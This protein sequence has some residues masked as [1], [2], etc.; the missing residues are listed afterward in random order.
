MMTYAWKKSQGISEYVLL[1]AAVV[2]GI[3]AM[4]FYVG[5]S[6]KGYLKKYSDTLG[7]QYSAHGQD[8]NRLKHVR[9]VDNE[10][11]IT[12]D[13][14]MYITKGRDV[15][16]RGYKKTEFKKHMVS[17]TSDGSATLTKTAAG[18]FFGGGVIDSD[19]DLVLG[20]LVTDINILDGQSVVE[21]SGTGKINEEKLLDQSK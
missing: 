18:T 11:N 6:K 20:E 4:S 19:V 17:V 9:Y 8:V 5:R 16:A 12:A 10:G 7:T 15:G 13:E 14:D 1:S 2:A 21:K 3:L